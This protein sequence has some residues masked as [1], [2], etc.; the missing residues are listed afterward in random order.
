[1]LQFQDVSFF[2]GGQAILHQ[3]SWQVNPSE[4]VGLV[5][6]NGCGKSTVLNLAARRIQP[7]GG[8]VVTAR[9][10]RIGY[11]PQDQSMRVSG[12]LQESLLEPFSDVL[13]LRR[14]LNDLEGRIAAGNHDSLLVDRA[15]A[16]RHRYEDR[17]GYTL[18]PRIDALI[19][20]LGF[21]H[22]DLGRP[23]TSFSGGERSRIALAKVLIQEPDLLLLDEPT[24]HLD[25]ESTERLEARLATYSG[26][27]VVVS[28]DR[29][30]LNAVCTSIVE[31]VD[32]TMES[33]FGNF[34][35]YRTLRAQR[36]EAL[37]R[38]IAKQKAEI[39]RIEDY[40]ARNMAG[41]K[42]RQARSKKH[43]LDRIDR[44]EV[45]KDPWVRAE[46]FRLRFTL[47]EQP[48]GKD[49]ILAEDLSVG[50]DA[51]LVEGLT[52]SVYRGDRVGIVG[53]NGTGKSTLLR[54]LVDRGKPMAG[55]LR[56]GHNLRIGYF[57]Q[58]RT[59][60][61]PNNDLVD[62]IRRVRGE[63]STDAARDILGALR[64][65]GDDVFRKVSS[66]SGGEQN[67]LAL[68]KLSLSPWSVLVLDEPT[69]HLDIPARQAL[70]RCLVEYSG[71]LV[72][73]SHDRY[74][75]DRL[76][77]KLVVLTVGQPVYVYWGNYAEYRR[78]LAGGIQ[79]TGRMQE[80][81][82]GD[83]DKD[84]R[85]AQYRARKEHKRVVDR[86]S[87]RCRDFEIAI[88][89]LERQ[90]EALDGRIGSQGIIWADLEA[91]VEKRTKLQ[92]ELDEKLAHWE[93]LSVELEHLSQ[94]RVD[95]DQEP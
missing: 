46:D 34:D 36:V 13:D 31:L 67:R 70:E 29:A 91:L 50:Y 7:H 72:V 9:G 79:Q 55:K 64:F 38:F 17:G 77:T 10:C 61:D 59:D 2:Y 20:E 73:V 80:R 89:E 68:G 65:S 47:P 74:F 62:E 5:G 58:N 82:G 48:G 30:F 83:E 87:R 43:V 3:A 52:L 88:S 54:V 35:R 85:L 93:Q 95:E 44:I 49:V 63:V 81:A 76:V 18:E 6:P 71:T 21:C 25:I 16:V 84:V 28:H 41:Q 4:R 92:T 56:F 24:N 15:G 69:N 86:L 8:T 33:F 42:A 78:S 60:L 12:S 1:M 94:E 51:P 66:L 27:V 53:P 11:L 37:Q 26:A 23:M 45:P 39:A 14:E 32:G 90:I 19:S 75:L 57:D 22:E 40:V